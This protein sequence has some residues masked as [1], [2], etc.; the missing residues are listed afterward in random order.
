MNE[1]KFK[2]A[3]SHQS[4]SG[5]Y[6]VCLRF[7]HSDAEFVYPTGEKCQLAESDKKEKLGRGE[8]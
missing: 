4:N 7:Y 1:I 2:L 5:E 8:Y 6:P 3:K